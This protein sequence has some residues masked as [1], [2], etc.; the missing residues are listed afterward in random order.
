MLSVGI[1][2][3]KNSAHFVGLSIEGTKPK[4]QFIEEHFFTDQKEEAEK[5]LFISSILENIYKNNKGEALRFCYGL[6]QN[7]VTS[8]LVRFPFKEKFKI[9]KTLPFEIEHQTPFQSSKVFF[10]ARICKIKDQKESHSVCFVT[11]EENV[12]K[13][14]HFKE[15]LYKKPYLLSCEASALANVL[16]YWNKPLSQAQKAASHPFYLYLGA[17][18]SQILFYR[19]GH[20][21]QIFVLDW[22]I[23][24]IIKDMEKSYK[25]KTEKALEEFFEKSFILTSEKG[26]S[27]EQIFFSNLIKKKLPPLMRQIRLLKMSFETEQKISIEKLFVFGPGSMIKNLSAFLTAETSLTFSKLRSLELFPSLNLLEKSSALIPLGLSLEGLKRVPY[28]GLNFLKSTNKEPLSLFPKV[29]RKRV[30]LAFLVFFLFLQLMLLS[31]NRKVIR[32]LRKFNLS[33]FIMGKELLL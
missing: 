3:T 15:K 20:L 32:F 33:L 2:I 17:E 23:G 24:P 7:I 1:H 16:E 26:F 9:I 12:Q 14:I 11:P 5:A 10:D 27:K 4:I 21:E 13:F 6:S 18:N 31:E 19:E 29:W 8:F 22:S 28:E 25:L 30:S